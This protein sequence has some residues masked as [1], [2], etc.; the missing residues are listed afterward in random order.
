[1]IEAL[2][3]HMHGNGGAQPQMY[4]DMHDD[5]DDEDYTEDEDDIDDE[6]YEPQVGNFFF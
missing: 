6:Y 5:D 1:M 2:L 4:D 3:Q